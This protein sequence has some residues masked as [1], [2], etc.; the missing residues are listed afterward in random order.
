[1]KAQQFNSGLGFYRKDGSEEAAATRMGIAAGEISLKRMKSASWSRGTQVHLR[2]AAPVR[3][4]GSLFF[5]GLLVGRLSLPLDC[6][7]ALDLASASFQFV[8]NKFKL[9]QLVN[10]LNFK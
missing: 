8:E 6:T 9:S 7:P 5:W 1:M 10:S 2:A 4:G 3:S